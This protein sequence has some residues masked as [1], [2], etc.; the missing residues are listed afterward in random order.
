MDMQHHFIPPEAMKLVRK[1]P[2]HDFTYGLKRLVWAYATIQDIAAHIPYMD[3][4]G[5]DVAIL[6]TGSFSPNGYDFCQSC[7][8]GYAQVIKRY[9]DRF[10]GMILI[11]P[12]DGKKA[13]D[14]VKRGVEELG[15][16]GLALVS[17]YGDNMIDAPMMDPFW[18]I[19]IKYDMPIFI[20]PSIRQK[21][22]GGDR[23]DLAMKV[24]REYDIVKSFVE[25]LFGVVPRFPELK[26]IMAHFGGGLTTLKGRMLAWHQP[27]GFPMPEEDRGQG[28]SIYQAKELGTFDDYE[29]RT[30]NF[31][32]DSAGCGGWLPVIRTSFETLGA[33]HICFG[34]DFPY[35]LNKA[36]YVKRLLEEITGLDVSPEDQG[37]FFG[38]NLKRFFKV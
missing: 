35:E 13:L 28:V 6:S 25:I 26:V 37:K 30:K 33:D 17:S 5:I 16:F 8:N 36:P 38:G 4:A 3:A 15:L 7:N 23:H 10:K 27:E 14:E 1:T 32:Y 11:Y 12:P 18:E 2:E 31:L 22:W 24:S 19:A 21:L 34:T 29:A 9:P 20:H